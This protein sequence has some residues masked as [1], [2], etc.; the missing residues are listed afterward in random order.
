MKK[1]ILPFLAILLLAAC[2]NTSKDTKDYNQMAIDLCNCMR[3]LA[4][5]NQQI[6]SLV[7]EGKTQEVADL[8]AEVERIAAEGETCA[9]SLEEKYGVVEGA[10]EEKATAALKK[11]CPDIAAMLE[12]S[13]NAN[14]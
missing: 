9:T 4:D 1:L 2:K 6:K 14:Q 8:F 10:S 11:N 13:E 3:P 5:M 12:Q 7:R